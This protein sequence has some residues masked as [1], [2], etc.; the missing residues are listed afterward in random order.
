MVGWSVNW[1]CFLDVG[2]LFYTRIH[3]YSRHTLRELIA[4]IAATVSKMNS[5]N[6]FLRLLF[7]ILVHLK[8]VQIGTKEFK[9]RAVEVSF[10]KCSRSFV[11]QMQSK[12]RFTNAIEV[13]FHKCNRSFVS[14]MQSKFRLTNA[15][16][17]SFNK[18]NRSFV[19]QMQAKFRFTN[20]TSLQ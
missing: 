1:F 10:H 2:V 13:S 17:V 4:I 11:S 14:Q 9:F 3:L 7:T 18:C 5:V 20:L 15:I 6:C 19:S 16:K 12:F 8:G